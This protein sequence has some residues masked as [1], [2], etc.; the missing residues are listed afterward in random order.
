MLP[1]LIL[2]G[3]TLASAAIGASG[4]KGKATQYETKT[5][6]QKQYLN[7][8]LA[9]QG[10]VG[11]TKLH[12]QGSSILEDL[13]SNDPEA[14][15]RFQ[16]PYMRHFHEQVLPQIAERYAG[17]GG[18]SSSAFR[19][20]L[21]QAAGGLEEN[22][23]NA[24]FGMLGQAL[25]YAQAPGDERMRAAGEGMFNTNV[26]PGQPSLGQSFA[27][28]FAGALSGPLAQNTAD[29]YFPSKAPAGVQ[30]APP[31]VPQQ[32]LSAYQTPWNPQ[33]NSAMQNRYQIQ[34]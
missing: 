13:L 14:V 19:Q 24:R 1:A 2:G 5:P 29:R 18:L 31:E 28:N 33:R 16:A 8:I 25:Q 12:Q 7:S 22:L 32:N 34:R 15:K 21:G 11:S 23:A 10:G 6:Q 27:T 26:Q 20:S 30:A 3:A 17:L 4:K 9:G